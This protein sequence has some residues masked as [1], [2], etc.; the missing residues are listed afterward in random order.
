MA[1]PR[2]ANTS[3]CSFLSIRVPYST[4]T[5]VCILSRLLCCSQACSC[6][7]A[8]FVLEQTISGPQSAQ[9]LFRRRYP[10]GSFTPYSKSCPAH[11]SAPPSAP[12]A[13][14]SSPPRTCITCTPFTS[15][16]TRPT[17]PVSA[18][19][20]P[21]PL[22]HRLVGKSLILTGPPQQAEPQNTAAPPSSPPTTHPDH[23][24]HPPPPQASLL[25]AAPPQA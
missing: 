7:S 21:A 16:S 22:T 24:H 8:P 23:H 25:T 15:P 13:L 18:S 5:A 1:V 10:L 2:P 9:K 11:Q 17:A 14:L 20:L 12:R 4:T 3:R 6:L 19:R